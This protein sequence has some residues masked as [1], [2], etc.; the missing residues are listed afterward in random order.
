M[1]PTNI[2]A[3]Q[4]FHAVILG[5]ALAG[6]GLIAV[7]LDRYATKLQDLGGSDETVGSVRFAAA[8]LLKLDLAV[9][10]VWALVQVVRVLA[11]TL[12]W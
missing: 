9:L 10:L 4:L 6:F 3:D 2:L 1:C 8:A 7:G 12:T 5:L 11:C